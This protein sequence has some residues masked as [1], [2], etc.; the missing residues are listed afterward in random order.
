[1]HDDFRLKFFDCLLQDTVAGTSTCKA[2]CLCVYVRLRALCY[3][4]HNTREARLSDAAVCWLCVSICFQQL[5]AEQ[6]RV[7]QLQAESAAGRSELD[8][9]R[10]TITQLRQQLTEAQ[11]AQVGAQA[12]SAF[13]LM[14]VHKML[15]LNR[16][17]GTRGRL[18]TTHAS[19]SDIS[20]SLLLTALAR[21]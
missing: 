11:T 15:L 19:P 1:M 4:G 14:L 5:A 18:P 2:V 21:G 8:N 7:G 17:H 10:S 13:Q 9:L 3:S 16:M 6:G 12:R 20:F